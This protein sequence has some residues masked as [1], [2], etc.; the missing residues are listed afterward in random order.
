MNNEI[1]IL[2]YTITIQYVGYLYA[3]SIWLPFYIQNSMKDKCSSDILT[4]RMQT[5]VPVLSQIQMQTVN[6]NVYM[7]ACV[8]T[9][10]GD[11]TS[12]L[13]GGMCI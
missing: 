5:S 9:P 8:M 12:L 6:L 2:I 1:C 4:F 10:G 3:W 13:S 7:Y 11:L